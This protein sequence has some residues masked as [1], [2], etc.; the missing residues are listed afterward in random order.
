[1]KRLKH[2]LYRNSYTLIAAGAI[3]AVIAVGVA[4]AVLVHAK[5]AKAAN[6]QV[7]A[8]TTAESTL[9]AE[10]TAL[11]AANKAKL[12]GLVV[13]LEGSYSNFR[14]VFDVY[15]DAD[16]VKTRVDDIIADIR[17]IDELISSSE[18]AAHANEELS[19]SGSAVSSL[20]D[21]SKRSSVNQIAEKEADS[22]VYAD[23]KVLNTIAEHLL[24]NLDNAD[25]YRALLATLDDVPQI[26][27]YNAALDE[28]AAAEAAAAAVVAESMVSED[29]SDITEE[30][31]HANDEVSDGSDAAPLTMTSNMS[32]GVDVSHYQSDHGTID[33]KQVKDSGITFAIIKCGGR[34]TG[35]DGKLYKDSAFEQNIVGALANGIQV[36]VYF[37][38]Q[39]RNTSEAAAEADYCLSLIQKYKI[40]YPVAFDWESA[41][42]YRVNK[43]NISNQALT[44]ICTTFADKIAAAGYTPMIYFCRN[45]WY[46]RVNTEQLTSRYKVWLAYYFKAYYYT[47]RQWQVGDDGPEVDFNYD[48]WQYGVT[49]TVPGINYYTDMNIA[50]FSYDNYSIDLYEASLTVDSDNIEV[51]YG[52]ASNFLSQCHAVNCLGVDNSVTVKIGNKSYSST[53]AID[54]ITPG[55]YNVTVSFNDPLYGTLSKSITLVVTGSYTYDED[56]SYS[57]GSS[58]STTGTSSSGSTTSGTTAGSTS[59]TTSTTAGST[60]GSSSAS[61]PSSGAGTDS[62]TTA[63]TS[64]SSTSPSS[65]S[66]SGSGSGSDGSGG[67][68]SGGGTVSGADGSGSS[69]GSAGSG[70][71]S[72]ADG[73]S[74]SGSGDASGSTV[75]SPII[76]DAGTSG[77]ASN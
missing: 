67:S 16:T 11:I 38:S 74:G 70:S 40:T 37:F 75:V 55:T 41:S 60:T 69:D 39:A 54:R 18:F 29:N 43:V 31:E 23:F 26:D 46:N 25:D 49:N 12:K 42:G 72:G 28:K 45:D 59:T 3:A 22:L 15:T 73:G 7:Q 14:V 48:M 35:S 64:S 50:M 58:D 56:Y 57:S 51:S 13:N 44:N 61:T 24:S 77:S 6:A 68:G 36:G 76:S 1:M 5:N 65:S 47:E 10:E 17:S 8:D 2:F 9:S 34:S 21:D 19:A 20:M 30:D 52:S 66:G 4:A 71:G 33:W 53:D 62:S 32:F 27:E 63:S